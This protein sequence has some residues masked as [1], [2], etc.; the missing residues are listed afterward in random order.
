MRPRNETGTFA[1]PPICEG[2]AWA[3]ARTCRQKVGSAHPATLAAPL[4]L[5]RD[6]GS[7]LLTCE[8]QLARNSVSAAR[9]TVR[10]TATY[11]TRSTDSSH[12]R[13]PTRSPSR[14]FHEARSCLST[15]RSPVRHAPP[16][17]QTRT[18]GQTRQRASHHLASTLDRRA[19]PDRSP[20]T[21]HGPQLPREPDH[22]PPLHRLLRLPQ[23]PRHMTPPLSEASHGT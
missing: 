6:G 9:T 17:R 3:S 12:P 10:T 22:F 7:V 16:H 18:F 15:A 20:A 5:Q 23:R 11:R 1:S 13:R 21:L 4:E 14:D 19:L 2:H 8:C